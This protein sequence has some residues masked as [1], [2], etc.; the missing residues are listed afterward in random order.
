MKIT[1]LGAVAMSNFQVNVMSE[2]VS[3]DGKKKLVPIERILS[4]K[5]V[6][7]GSMRYRGYIEY[8]KSCNHASRCDCPGQGYTASDLGKEVWKRFRPGGTDI[9]KAIDPATGEL[10]SKGVSAWLKE[11]PAVW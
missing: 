1:E 11:D 8:Q 3:S 4:M 10:K 7:V 2:F 5:Q 6:S 9:Q